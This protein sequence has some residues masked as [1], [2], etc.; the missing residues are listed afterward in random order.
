MKEGKL[1]ETGALFW[2]SGAFEYPGNRAAKRRP[3]ML[4]RNMLRH[5]NGIESSLGNAET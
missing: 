4:S 1:V 2:V 3:P 5:Y